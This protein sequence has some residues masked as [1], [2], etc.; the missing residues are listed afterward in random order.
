MPEESSGPPHPPEKWIPA[1]PFDVA[2]WGD[3]EGEYEGG[4]S[5]FRPE[6]EFEQANRDSRD[7]TES[8]Q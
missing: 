6:E 1:I 4:G 2:E 3:K 7:L 8:P 5:A